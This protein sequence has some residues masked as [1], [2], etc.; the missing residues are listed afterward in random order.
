MN[1]EKVEFIIKIFSD[2]FPFGIKTVSTVSTVSHENIGVIKNIFLAYLER[3]GPEIA[4]VVE[5]IK[6]ILKDELSR[7]YQL[8]NQSRTLFMVFFPH[9]NRLPRTL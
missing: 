8:L 9:K 4:N 7:G 6:Q 5:V 2:E 1:Q 3:A